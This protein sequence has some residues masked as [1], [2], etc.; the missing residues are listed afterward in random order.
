[1][2][3]GYNVL[4]FPEGT[5]STQGE[6]AHFRGGIGMLAKQSGAAVLPVAIRGL[7]ALK[8]TQRGWFRSGTIEVHVGEPIHFSPAETE[9]GITARLHAEVDKLLHG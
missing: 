8:A 9:A 3:H 5:R 6:L 2:D 4:I 7:G 1:M